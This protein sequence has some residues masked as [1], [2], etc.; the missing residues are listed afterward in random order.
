MPVKTI[1]QRQCPPVKPRKAHDDGAD[2][3]SV[4][5]T[6]GEKKKSS[7]AKE[8]GLL[9]FDDDDE[10]EHYSQSLDTSKAVAESRSK[11]S[12]EKK[13]VLSFSDEGGENKDPS[14][15]HDKESQSTNVIPEVL[16]S[17][18]EEE[19]EDGNKNLSKDKS[20]SSSSRSVTFKEEIITGSFCLC[21]LC[22]SNW[23]MHP[24]KVLFFALLK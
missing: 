9:C 23:I 8:D 7:E 19:E 20:L 11:I 16:I 12:Q 14:S 5:S 4:D 17:P 2:N 22:L 3:S 1:I 6:T 21:F 18:L 13:S 15:F 24:L 10:T